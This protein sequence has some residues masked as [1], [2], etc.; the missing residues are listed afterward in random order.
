MQRRKNMSSVKDMTLRSILNMD[1]LFGGGL[2]T[3]Y[4]LYVLSDVAGA[5]KNQKQYVGEIVDILDELSEKNIHEMN[6][7]NKTRQ[8]NEEIIIDV[9]HKVAKNIMVN[10]ADQP[11]LID[12]LKGI[13]YKA[14]KNNRGYVDFKGIYRKDFMKT[15]HDLSVKEKIEENKERLRNER[16]AKMQAVK[17]KVKENKKIYTVDD[18]EFKEYGKKSY[19]KGSLVLKNGLTFNAYVDRYDYLSDPDRYYNGS[20]RVEVDILDKNGDNISGKVCLG[21]R[22]EWDADEDVWEA[23]GLGLGKNGYGYLVEGSDEAPWF[24]IRSKEDLNNLLLDAQTLDANGKLLN[25]EGISGVVV[26]DKIAEGVRD[27]VVTEPTTPEKGKKIAKNIKEKYLQ[28]KI[29]R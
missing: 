21:V 18:L 4:G 26:A 9:M 1:N 28:K 15:D 22:S 14:V 19:L 7:K 17:D 11:E 10:N 3:E 12:K 23:Y 5:T 2:K 16:I 8:A 27:G 13:M 20:N 29:S 24:D 25:I 6:V